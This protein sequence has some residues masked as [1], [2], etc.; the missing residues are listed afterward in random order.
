MKLLFIL[1]FATSASASNSFYFTRPGNESYELL[2]LAK[3]CRVA[4]TKGQRELRS[5]TISTA[6]GQ[7]LLAKA[8]ASIREFSFAGGEGSIHVSV[9]NHGYSKSL[10]IALP[11]SGVSQIERAQ[12]SLFSTQML[13]LEHQLK[14]R[15]SD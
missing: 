13:A 6:D 9:E 3:S 10:V 7:A 14:K 8:E 1:L 5:V 11:D 2:C 15:L 4:E 12:R